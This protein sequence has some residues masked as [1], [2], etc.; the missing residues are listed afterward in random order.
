MPIECCTCTNALFFIFNYRFSILSFII[1]HC[2]PNTHSISVFDVCDAFQSIQK[3]NDS[4][5]TLKNCIFRS[6]F[7]RNLFF[8]IVRSSFWF[9]GVRTRIISL[10]QDSLLSGLWFCEIF[11]RKNFDM[12]GSAWSWCLYVVF[13]L[14][15]FTK[16]LLVTPFIHIWTWKSILKTN[17]WR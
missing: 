9:C 4:R 16:Y 15:I 1:I 7:H 5:L 10:Y 11:I 6:P 8:S 13:R 14:L 17:I 12:T 2:V 3:Q